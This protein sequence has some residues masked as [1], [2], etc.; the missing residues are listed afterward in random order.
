MSNHRIPMKRHD[1][2]PALVLRV[3]TGDAPQ[4]IS[5]AT[6]ARLIVSNR[7]GVK[8]NAAMEILDDGTEEMRGLVRYSWVSGDTDTPGDF[9]TEVEVT[10]PGSRPQTFPSEGYLVTRVSKDLA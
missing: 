6:S 2:E 3:L 4:D 8:I 7:L 5:E 10:W 1:L 9:K